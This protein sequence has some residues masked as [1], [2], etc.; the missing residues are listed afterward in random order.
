MRRRHANVDDGDVRFLVGDLA[1]Q[2][3]GIGRLSDDLEAC[4]DEQARHALPEEEGVVGD[5][6]SHGISA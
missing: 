6:D 5:Y 3:L 1:E 4:L 2:L